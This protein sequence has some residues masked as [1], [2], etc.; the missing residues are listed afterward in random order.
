MPWFDSA[1]TYLQH[2]TSK[3]PEALAQ[4]TAKSSLNL[5]TLDCHEHAFLS[6]VLQVRQYPALVL[7]TDSGRLRDWPFELKLLDQEALSFLVNRHWKHLPVYQLLKSSNNKQ[8]F[9]FTTLQIRAFNLL[10][11]FLLSKQPL[12][13]NWITKN[14]PL[15][16]GI[17]GLASVLLYKVL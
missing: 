15:T 14:R 4:A 9:L 1:A 10:T 8:P 11:G 6:A 2:F 5:A 17:L 16:T 12:L 7:V 13:F 3:F